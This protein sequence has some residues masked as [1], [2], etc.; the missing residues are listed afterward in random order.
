[1]AAAAE[2]KPDT[3]QAFDHYMQITEE[4]REARL[5]KSAAFLWIDRQP[6]ARRQSMYEK[7]KRGEM[8]TERLETRDD[9]RRMPVPHGM[10]HHYVAVVFIPGATAA[11]TTALMQSYARYPE[12]FTFGVERAKVL[13]HEGQDFKAGLR[14]FRKGNSPLFYNVDLDDQYTTVDRTRAY[15]RS[16]STRIAEI[17]DAGKPSEH[18]MP[19]GRDRGFLWRMNTNWSVEEKGGGVYLEIELIALSRSVPAAFAW[20]ANPVIRGIPQQ[21]LEQTLGAMR[22]SLTRKPTEP[23]T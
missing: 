10:I 22:A 9:N 6:E 11:E 18:E 14:M 19:V 17:S 13:G 21:Y 2:L 3:I 16:R 7:L 1:M 4:Q 12:I 20:L 23:A 5:R 8:V 15:R